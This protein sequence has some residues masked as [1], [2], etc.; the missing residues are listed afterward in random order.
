MYSLEALW[1]GRLKIKGK[2]VLV[3]IGNPILKD[4]RVGI[5]VAENV[6]SFLR[7]NGFENAADVKILYNSGLELLEEIRGYDRAVIVDAMSTGKFEPGVIYSYD[8]VDTN[9]AIYWF[10]FHGIDI[11]S[12]LELGKIL[13]ISLPTEI[14]IWGI[15]VKDSNIFSE[16]L[17]TVVEESVPRV[18]NEIYQYLTRD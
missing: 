17:S 6:K 9:K 10:S 1:P 7:Q 12:L 13:E 4:D 5:V 14:R 16:D 15:E 18:V 8:I 2:T 3:G 11:L